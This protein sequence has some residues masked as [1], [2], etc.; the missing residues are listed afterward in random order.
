MTTVIDNSGTMT[1]N[2][3]NSTVV[4]VI[5]S[6]GGTYES[7][8]DNSGSLVLNNN[9]RVLDSGATLSKAVIV[10]SGSLTVNSGATVKAVSTNNTK[11]IYYTGA[12]TS[13]SLV[14]NGTVLNSYPG[15]GGYAIYSDASGFSDYTHLGI[16]SEYEAFLSFAPMA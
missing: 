1:V 8:I 3:E 5:Y 15:L 6:E 7:I 4:S 2:D 13:S 16:P 11:T 12:I 10:S 9:A 14:I